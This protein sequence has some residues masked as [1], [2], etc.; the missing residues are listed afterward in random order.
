MCCVRQLKKFWA[1]RARTEEKRIPGAVQKLDKGEKYAGYIEEALKCEACER[2]FDKELL[3][4]MLDRHVKGIENNARVL[5]TV[6]AFL[7]WYKRYFEIEPIKTA[8]Y[9]DDDSSCD[10]SVSGKEI[11]ADQI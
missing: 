8:V 4:S 7:V 3:H 5:Y 6:Y 10:E 11:T 9:S 1:E 2:Y